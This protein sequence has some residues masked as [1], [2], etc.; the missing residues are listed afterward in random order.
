VRTHPTAPW[1]GL[2]RGSATD[3]LG[4]F[5]KAEV[6]LMLSSGLC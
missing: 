2:R 1:P 6:G 4:Q 5:W 3:C